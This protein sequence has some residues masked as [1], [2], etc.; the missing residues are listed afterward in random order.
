MFEKPQAEHE[1][2]NQLV[3]EWD[4]E[5]ESTMGPDQP[6]TK[7]TSSLSCHMLNGM[8]LICKWDMP[9]TE[10]EPINAIMTIGYDIEQKQY[11]GTFITTCMS[12]LWLYSCSMDESKR[13]LVLNSEGPAFDGKGTAKY[14][15]IITLD[16]HDHWMF[17]SQVQDENGQW[18]PFMSAH[19]NRKK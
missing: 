14:Q 5:S 13:T 7:S 16:T 3:G 8:W 10:S 9:S 11:T 18:N 4:V 19:H 2:L 12:K 6:S 1:W 17:S 15:D